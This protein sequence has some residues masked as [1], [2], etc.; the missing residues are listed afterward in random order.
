MG[1]ILCLMAE[2]FE[3]LELISVCDILRRAGV[4]VTLAGQEKIENESAHG[5]IMKADVLLKD[6][7]Q[8]E[9]AGL[10][11]PGGSKGAENLKNDPK[12]IELIN[13]F[14]KEEKLIAAICAGPLVLK[15]AGIIDQVHITSY[16]SLKDE[17]KGSFYEDDATSVQEGHILTSRGPAT[18]PFLAFD[19]LYYLKE[20]KAAE[21]I[22]EDM[23]FPILATKE[24]E[25]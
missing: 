23:L 19:I 21:R 10:Y 22:Y 14:D 15:E 5:F 25:D 24:I 6:I 1:K 16:P 11:I 7:D 4:E 17:F 18:A 3:E 8:R 13:N 2:G 20:E 12:V 9:F